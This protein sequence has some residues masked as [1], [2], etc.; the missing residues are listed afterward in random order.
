MS[1]AD[2]RTSWEQFAREDPLWFIL[3]APGREHA[4]REDEFMETGRQEVATVLAEIAEL[5]V[6]PRLG[7]A[8][9]FGCGVGRICQALGD[10]FDKVWGVDIA[11]PMIELAN[12]R[13]T[14]GDKVEYVL[15]TAGR[16]PMFAAGSIDFVYSNLVLQHMRPE[17]ARGY[18]QEFMRVLA[19]GGLAVFQLPS[20]P[21]GTAYAARRAV[22][23]RTP[24]VVI[25]TYHR[26]RFG[27]WRRAELHG[28]E[29]PRV[30]DLVQ[31]NGGE[32]LAVK[33]D[34]GAGPRWVSRR[35]FV[36]KRP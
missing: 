25:K 26:V 34:Q 36:R 15:N 28:V 11:S 9:D 23:D 2:L 24:D 1:L 35:Y 22:R 31:R 8:L 12:A 17:F 5:G 3:A 6:E 19:P 10:H 14:H 4:W 21:V 7:A 27:S 29:D 20:H 33:T 13:N 32:V 16:L 30:I 18:I